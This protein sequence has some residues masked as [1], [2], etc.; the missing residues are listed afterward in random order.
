MVNVYK[1]RKAPSYLVILWRILVLGLPAGST[2]GSAVKVRADLS[3]NGQHYPHV[4][5]TLAEDDDPTS[6]LTVEVS[7]KTEIREKRTVWLHT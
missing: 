4:C 7:G 5:A 1:C 2:L 3:P 6:R